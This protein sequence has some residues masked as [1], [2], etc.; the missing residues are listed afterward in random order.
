MCCRDQLLVAVDHLLHGGEY[1]IWEAWGQG[2]ERGRIDVVER[3]VVG[4]EHHD[5]V[6][7]AGLTENVAVEPIEPTLSEAWGVVE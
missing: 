6:P 7:H 2:S 4:S 5:D 1:E 3:E